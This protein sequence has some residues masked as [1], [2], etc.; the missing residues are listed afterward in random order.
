MFG[1]GDRMQQRARSGFGA[2]VA[3]MASAGQVTERRS[4]RSGATISGSRRRPMTN[5]ATIAAAASGTR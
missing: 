4:Q 3:S 2:P 5:S 1:C